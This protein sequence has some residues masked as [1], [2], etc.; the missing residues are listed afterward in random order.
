[1]IKNEKGLLL[2]ISGPSGVGKGTVCRELLNDTTVLSVSATTRAPRDGEKDGV[3]YFFYDKKKFENMIENNELMEWAEYCD[4]Y[5]GTPRSFVEEHINQ[6]KNV[7]L[8]IE[9]QGAMHIK[10]E[11]PEGVYIF[12][13]PPSLEELRN[14][15]IGRG[16]ETEDVIDNRM[17]QVTREL[18]FAGEYQYLV[19]NDKIEQAVEDIRSIIRAEKSKTERCTAE[20]L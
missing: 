5:Y 15:I 9:V 4:N 8:E 14:R 2:V 10:E 17:A 7:I 16:T 19:E 12:I 6:G 1:M 11:H 13:L 3:N 20:L 18:S